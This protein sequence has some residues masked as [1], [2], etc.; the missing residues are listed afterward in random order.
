MSL[1]PRIIRCEIGASEPFLA[2]LPQYVVHEG[3]ETELHRAD[4]STD[5]SSLQQADA[6]L[7]FTREEMRTLDLES[8]VE[9][10]RGAGKQLA[11]QEAGYMFGKINEAAARVGNV[12]DADGRPFG[13]DVFLEALEHIEI[14]FDPETEEP[15][16][17]SMVIPESRKEEFSAEMATWENDEDFKREFD[18]VMARKKE[19][20]R[21]RES[22]R[23]LV[24]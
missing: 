9:R 12:T 20:W 23:K 24:D 17:P 19:Q 5:S 18:R 16:G 8:F 10:L 14:G 21:D 4:D 1:V 2:R 6:G 22:S 7:L 11:D 15:L 13:K 3:Q